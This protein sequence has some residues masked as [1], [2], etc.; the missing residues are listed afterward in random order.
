VGCGGVREEGA[1][2]APSSPCPTPLSG[3]SGGAG[4]VRHFSVREARRFTV[5]GLGSKGLGFRVQPT[6]PRGAWLAAPPHRMSS[7]LQ[8]GSKQFSVS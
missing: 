6:L 7:S 3:F 5:Y 2:V 8:A 1:Y 4:R